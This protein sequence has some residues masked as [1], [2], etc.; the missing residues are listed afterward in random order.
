MLINNVNGDLESFPSATQFL[1]GIVVYIFRVVLQGKASIRFSPCVISQT[2]GCTG[3][4]ACISQTSSPHLCHT[5]G[6]SKNQLWA[7]REAGRWRSEA[8]AS[9][10]LMWF[11]CL[12]L[13]YFIKPY[14]LSLYSLTCDHG[15]SRT[16]GELHGNMGKFVQL[17]GCV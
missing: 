3:T 1:L 4:H 15:Y 9:I 14:V 16:Q 11:C 12:I 8:C 10:F 7:L 13:S 5:L 2:C 17:R 6:Y